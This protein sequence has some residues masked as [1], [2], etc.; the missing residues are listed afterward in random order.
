MP[1]AS[2]P[3]VTVH[4]VQL[5]SACFRGQLVGRR[6][7]GSVQTGFRPDSAGG[8]AAALSFREILVSPGSCVRERPHSPIGRGTG[9]KIR[10]V[11]VRIRLGAPY[12]LVMNPLD[13]IQSRATMLG[14]RPSTST[15]LFRSVITSLVSAA[16]TGAVTGAISGCFSKK[17]S[18]IVTDG[19]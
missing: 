12:S 15:C 13:T 1:A 14:S 9:L 8:P 11:S 19:L 16:V 3:A 7:V 18:F 4:F 6:S 10:Q 17:L 5:E 2:E